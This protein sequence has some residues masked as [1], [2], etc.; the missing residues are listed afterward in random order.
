MI[1]MK[2]IKTLMWLGG[3]LALTGVVWPEPA[4]A[5]SAPPGGEWT[6]VSTER[7]ETMR[8]GFVAPSGL[9][10]SFGIERVA[11]V[12]GE[13]VTSSTLRVPDVS[14][15]TP[16]QAQALA[17]LAATQVV[18]VGDGNLVQPGNGAG[19]VIQNTLDGQ[20]VSALTTLDVSVNTL[21]LL[22]ELNTAATLHDA[23]VGAGAS[24]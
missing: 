20:V 12:N 4:G 3:A 18:R 19:L 21:G 14:R 2:R 17:S 7:L 11:F 9:M 13:L 22:Q 5:Q 1:A 16:E 23:L 15:M 8:G 6:P 10:L 24:P